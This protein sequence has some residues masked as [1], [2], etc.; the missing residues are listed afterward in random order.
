[1][2]GWPGVFTAGVW[3]AGLPAFLALIGAEVLWRRGPA[4]APGFSARQ[5]F[6]VPPGEWILAFFKWLGPR[7]DAFF[8]LEWF[9]QTLWRLYQGAARLMESI[10]TILEGDGGVLW[11][12][13]LL[14]LVI[15]LLQQGGIR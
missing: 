2:R 1:V 12:M 14:G 4:H 13:L 11:A 5:L 7:L 6:H 9:Y 8:R 15:S 3:W 10:T